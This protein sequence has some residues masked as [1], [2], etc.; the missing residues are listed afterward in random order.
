M[1][2]VSW[3]SSSNSSICYDQNL[4][5]RYQFKLTST[6]KLKSHP[7]CYPKNWT[8]TWLADFKALSIL[9]TMLNAFISFYIWACLLQSSVHSLYL[10]TLPTSS[11]LRACSTEHSFQELLWKKSVLLRHVRQTLHI[12]S[13]SWKSTRF[14]HILKAPRNPAEKNMIKKTV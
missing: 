9:T 3:L 13:P 1:E 5:W 7:S 4:I 10:F 11:V 2:F 6:F 8:W 14:T 12:I